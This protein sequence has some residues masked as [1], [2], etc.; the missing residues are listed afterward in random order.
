[1]SVTI[2]RDLGGYLRRTYVRKLL[3]VAEREGFEPPIPVKVWPL[4][5]RLVS[6]THAPLR[7]RKRGRL[8]DSKPRPG[9]A[10]RARA[11]SVLTL[12]HYPRAGS[13]ALCGG[14][15]LA[16]FSEERLHQVHAARGQNSRTDLY[17][18][19]ELGMVEHLQHG[20]HRSGLGVFRAID[21]APDSR[22]RDGTGAHGAGLDS[23]VEIAI[24]QAIVADGPPRF[25]KCKY[26][27]VR[28]RIVGCERAVESAAYESS[29]VHDDRPDGNFAHRQ[30][31]LCLAQRF[32][33]PELVGE[34]HE[35]SG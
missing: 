12:G 6:T 21:Q 19:V 22:V 10:K 14:F 4:S 16:L 3:K 34:G 13:T 26:F 2:R 7:A 18:V 35:N 27:G 11:G 9:L 15:G 1:M 31:A 32:F 20:M 5:R 33:H 29:A 28:C 25:S 17:L 30:G 8:H 24:E 23:H